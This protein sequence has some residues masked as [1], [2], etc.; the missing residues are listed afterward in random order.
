MKYVNH[1]KIN[2]FF[3]N[4]KHKFLNR[5]E[6]EFKIKENKIRNDDEEIQKKLLEFC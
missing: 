3:F 2:Y 4:S 6:E 5:E 1:M